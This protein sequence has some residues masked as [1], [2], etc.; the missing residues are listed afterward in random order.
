MTLNIHAPIYKR[1]MDG[2]RE[3][4]HESLYVPRNTRIIQMLL[5]NAPSVVCMQEFW[6]AN[7][8]LVALYKRKMEAAGY[9]LYVTPRTGDRGDGLCTAVQEA[10][11]DVIDRYNIPFRDIGDRVAHLLHL[12]AIGSGY[13]EDELLLINL[14]LMFPHDTNCTVIRL[15]QCGKLLN[16]LKLYLEAKDLAR[17]PIVICGDW[18]GTSRGHLAGFMRSQGFISVYD[19]HNPGHRWVSHLN[20]NSQAVGVDCIWLLNPSAQAGSLTANWRRTA[21]A[22]IAAHLVQNGV[23]THA[24][25]FAFFDIAGRGF[26]TAED[27]ADGI[28]R[29]GLTGEHSIGLLPQEI[30]E[31]LEYCNADHNV[32]LEAAAFCQSIDVE[33]AALVLAQFNGDMGLYLTANAALS[34]PMKAPYHPRDLEIRHA[35]LPESFREGIWPEGYRDEI[36]DHAPLTALLSFPMGEP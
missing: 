29:L 25:A 12:K 27:F 31:L 18:N 32:E 33:Q 9:T 24:A 22:N 17:V 7:D 20:H 34:C 4:D 19:E 28:R 35:S 36:S 30:R 16:N 2:T 3:A 6:V 14:H 15:R 5:R 11:F 21:C 1:L 23:T 10:R 13:L 8:Q 26:L